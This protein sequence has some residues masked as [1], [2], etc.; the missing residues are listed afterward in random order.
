MNPIALQIAH[1]RLAGIA[2]EMGVILGRTALSPN[3][4]E[5]RDY[6]CAVF[7]ARGRLAA[8]AAHIPVHLGSTPLAVRAVLAA[9]ALGPG[10]VA[11]VNDPFAGGT[12]L[13][14]VT[15]VAPVFLDGA[16]Q[17][18]AY[19]ANRAHHADI[20]G[21]SPGSMPL[22]TEIFQEGLRLPPIRFVA[23]GRIVSDVLALFLANTRVSAEREGDLMAQWASLRVGAARLRTL[24]AR[25]GVRTVARDMAALQGYSAA[26][27]RATVARL[28]AGTFR[29]V[30]VLDDDGFGAERLRIAVAVTLRHGRARVD[31]TGSAPQTDGPVNANL[32]VTRSA[33]L[34]VFTALASEE[35]PPNDGLARPLT[36]VAPEGS[37]VNARFPAAVAGGN[38]E[39]SQRI[40]DV[41]LRALAR[42]APDRVPAASA[43]SM[44]NVALGGRGDRGEFA[45][46]ETLAG[47]A[48]AGPGGPGLSAVHTHMTNTMNTPVEA[49]EAYYPFR[50]T[51]YAVRRGS[52]GR[53]RHRGGDGVVREIE[54]LVP[55]RVTLLGERRRVPPYGL[56]GGGA[57]VTGRDW[58][59]HDGRTRRIPAKTSFAT[60]PGDRLRIETPGGGGWG[61]ARRR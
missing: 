33:V 15:L 44:N 13:P 58:L 18:F 20:G 12:H 48:G 45:Y 41:L 5:R 55:A 25:A 50:V 35:V 52:G 27:M 39:T 4:K 2:D 29:G 40:V 19:V 9:L 26:L 22:A 53:G 42:A 28:P 59:V 38:V 54:L 57:G 1:H 61:R 23:G 47:G 31:F 11:I 3:I 46:Y 34:Y 56:T 51:R 30:D 6:S 17:P 49:L 10:D 37:I 21:T 8:Q 16:R 43:G 32:A 7:D 60:A 14:D 36:I 24:A